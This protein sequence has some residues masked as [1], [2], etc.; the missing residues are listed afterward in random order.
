MQSDKHSV[1]SGQEIETTREA[2]FAEQVQSEDLEKQPTRKNRHGI[3]LVPQ[4]TDDP[5]D[6]LN[7]STARKSTTLA[8]LCLA[9][10]AGIVQALANSAGFFVQAELYHKSPVDVSY[11]LSA[12]IAGLAVGPLLWTPVARQLGKCAVIFWSLILTLCMNIWSA[13]MTS[14]DDYIPFVVS[15]LFAALFGSAASVVGSKFIIEVFFL[16]D[17]G[18][19]IAIYTCCVLLGTV[20]SATFSGFI[21]QDASWTVQFWYNVG[22]EGVVAVLCLIFLRETGWTRPGGPEFP[23]RPKT[24]FQEFTATYFFTRRTTPPETI[25][26]TFRAALLPLAIGVS[27]VT[28]LVGFPL[29]LYF[30]WS[31]A[32]TTLLSVFLQEPVEAGGYAFSPRRNAAF[33]FTQWVGVFVAQAYGHFVND[34]LPLAIC[35]R[36]GGKWQ[37]EYRLHSLWVPI[38]IV[39]PLGLGIFGA[40]LLYHWHYMVLAFAVFLITFSGVAGV[41]AVVNYVIEAFT[42]AYANEATGIMNFYRL[43]FGIA[44]NFFLFPWAAKVGI[45]WCFGMMAFFT[46]F[47]FLLIMI[48]M[49]YGETL[50]RYNLVK[51]KSEEGMMII[52]GH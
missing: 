16:H 18:K 21:V 3:A 38:L 17:R 20:A 44:L 2:E 14:G 34:R 27:P 15:R 28:M 35:A 29:M 24:R 49:R 47:A 12:A 46:I 25:A 26:Q 7:W 41:P 10:F 39:Y 8:I 36:R 33:T 52:R 42:P 30:S 9:S 37:A 1:A 31:V 50:R 5:E 19:C 32:V 45:N 51:A 22:V 40:S 48:P 43:V 4:P 13:R 11:S 6:P 23:P